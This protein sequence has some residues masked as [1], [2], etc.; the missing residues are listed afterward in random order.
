MKVTK[1]DGIFIVIIIALLG[2][3]FAN[4]RREKARH[5]PYDDKHNLFYTE[6]HTGGSRMEAEKKCT[7]CHSAQK[8]PLPAGHPPKEQCLVCHTLSKVSK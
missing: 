4:S 3:L 8:I 1:K 6:V 5:I 2:T 7:A